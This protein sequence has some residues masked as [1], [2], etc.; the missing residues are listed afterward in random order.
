MRSFHLAVLLLALVL[1]LLI[2]GCGT[3]SGPLESEPFSLE[4]ESD[5]TTTKFYAEGDTSLM[6][7]GAAPFYAGAFPL[8]GSNTA[9]FDTARATKIGE[10]QTIAASMRQTAA[11]TS[12]RLDPLR[13]ALFQCLDAGIKA[14]PELA[15]FASECVK[16]V[17]GCQTASA[18]AL[19]EAEAVSIPAAPAFST[20]LMEYLQVL[21]S[22]N[23][24]QT[25]LA[26]ADRLVALAALLASAFEKSGDAKLQ[27]AATSLD[28]AMG[29][30]D[31]L[32]DSLANLAKGLDSG[33]LGLKQLRTADHYL[34]LSA[35]EFATNEL[36]KARQNLGSLKPTQQITSDQITAIGQ[37]L[38][39][40]SLMLTL[41]QQVTAAVP[42][43]YLVPV[44]TETTYTGG[45]AWAFKDGGYYEMANKALKSPQQ[46][47]SG[48]GLGTVV[49]ATWKAVR[50]APASAI[51]MAELNWNTVVNTA[52]GVIV[53][54]KSLEAAK[55][56][57]MQLWLD[58]ESRFQAGTQGTE[59]LQ[60][61]KDGLEGMEELA[62]FYTSELASSAT[63]NYYIP[64]VTGK[65]AKAVVGMFTGLAKGLYTL[66]DPTADA[67]DLAGGLVDIAG[68]AIGGSKV[69]AKPSILQG[70]GKSFWQWLKPAGV[71]AAKEGLEQS[72][73]T[74]T[75][76][77]LQATNVALKDRLK[78]LAAAWA[79]QGGKTA[80]ESLNDFA[81]K[82]FE[83]NLSGFAKA[84]QTVIGERGGTF[85]DNVFSELMDN[86]L[87]SVVVETLGGP[88]FD[89]TYKGL[90]GKSKGANLVITIKGA[91]VTGTISASNTTDLGK[92]VTKG[93]ITGTFNPATRKLSARITGTMSSSK[94]KV[95]YAGTW[96]GTASQDATKLTGSYALTIT[97][98]GK[99][100]DSDDGS[101]SASK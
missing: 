23:A 12:P 2:I 37:V 48:P 90:A 85:I 93:A 40:F 17:L 20:S 66:A 86:M 41:A 67:G 76:Q 82:Q 72:A 81:T 101:W 62:E 98:D 39:S 63:P 75:S 25:T 46:A 47:S 84:L 69:L 15:S 65:V 97:F 53:D 32:G 34:V 95:T 8:P 88:G 64:E 27:E 49:A 38:E 31:G 42:D 13:K 21:R 14:K 55:A 50:N 18:V 58:A 24:A 77:A 54:G 59:V 89:G 36:P 44:E 100:I 28:T 73:T 9:T 91:T 26:E 33:L 16:D 4:F 1:A 7:V 22:F 94:G 61:A 19:A 79:A 60:G 29:A 96:N 74:A 3:K 71:E 5:A 11:D 30:L 35:L 6:L 80:A 51:E 70:S 10:I 45:I 78:A 43:S 52:Q 68:S 99:A 87:Q 83:A 92:L 57:Q 56:E